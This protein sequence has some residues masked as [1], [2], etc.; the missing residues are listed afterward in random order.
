MDKNGNME[1]EMTT[2]RRRYK[3]DYYS[4]LHRLLGNTIYLSPKQQKRKSE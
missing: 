3:G 4:T 2:R 1:F